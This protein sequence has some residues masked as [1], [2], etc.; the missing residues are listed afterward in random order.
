[1]IDPTEDTLSM[2]VLYKS[3]TTVWDTLTM[4]NDL[5][6]IGLGSG[7]Y[8]SSFIWL[9]AVDLPNVDVNARLKTIV[10]DNW[11]YGPETILDGIHVDN[12]NGPTLTNLSTN[13]IYPHINNS[14]LL[15]FSNSI[16]PSTVDSNAIN[17]TNLPGAELTMLS[18]TVI[19]VSRPFGY[20]TNS[21][22]DINITPYLRD[23]LDKPFDGNEDGDPSGDVEDETL[24]TITTELLG[25]FDS[26]GVI[27]R[28]DLERFE[29]GWN[30]SIP[31]FEMGPVKTIPGY[32]NDSAQ[33]IFQPDQK[34]D[35]DDLMMFVRMWNYCEDIGDCNG[36]ALFLAGDTENNGHLISNYDGENL[37][38]GFD[39]DKNP[40]VTEFSIEFNNEIVTL[41]EVFAD[42]SATKKNS[43]ILKRKNE[44]P[45]LKS[46]IL[47][48]LEKNTSDQPWIAHFPV[49]LKGKDPENIIIHY[50]YKNSDNIDVYGRNELSIAPIPKEFVL[51]QNYPN[52]FNPLTNIQYDIPE[53]AFVTINIYDILGRKIKTLVNEMNDAGFKSIQ[54]TA[55]NDFGEPVPSGIYFY[56]IMAKDYSSIK[57]MLLVK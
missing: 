11:G 46:Y 39:I 5:S 52:P 13:R 26:T 50:A 28:D 48:Y 9:T 7:D 35:I 29:E 34:Y 20:P 6:V 21:T 33:F 53:K 30:N 49:S 56:M 12:E 19:K 23:V 31:F 15:R 25:D 3:D 54:W 45:N 2:M 1:M 10:M 43:I 51:Y 14:V 37:S 41:G 16:D 36:Q 42:T 8:D 18:D 44:D 24:I 17:I 4:I 32:D 38:F 40:T 27:D 57:K 55:T 47:G 22:F